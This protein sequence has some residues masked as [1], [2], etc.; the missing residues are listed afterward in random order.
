[1]SNCENQL[2]KNI[3]CLRRAYCETQLELALAIGL[4]SPNSI[5]NYE[6]GER[7]PKPE[8]KKKIAAHFRITEDELIHTDFSSLRVSTSLFNDKNNMVDMT[9]TMFP[10]IQTENALKDPD[11]QKAYEAH[12]RAIEAMKAS[13]TFSD[14]DY[15]ICFRC[16]LESYDKNGIVE[17]VANILWWLIIFEIMLKN[18]WMIDGAKALNRKW[19]DGSQFVK[20]YYLRDMS[21]NTPEIHDQLITPSEMNDLEDN[22]IEML[23]EIKSNSSLSELA[24]YYIALRYSFGCINNELTDDMNRSIGNEMMWAFVQMG[25]KYAKKFMIKGLNNLKKTTNLTKRE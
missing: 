11:F 18:Q 20:K 1:M 6:K 2:A 23:R 25:N 21:E 7:N 8:I 10:V 4:D 19:I 9:F 5:A 14:T 24:D 17:A 22:I 15:E 16:Y 13:Q 3:K 12:M